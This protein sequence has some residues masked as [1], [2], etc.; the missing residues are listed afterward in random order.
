[1]SQQRKSLYHLNGPEKTA[2]AGSRFG[3]AALDTRHRDEEGL[4][5]ERNRQNDARVRGLSNAD[6]RPYRR[7]MPAPTLIAIFRLIETF[8]VSFIV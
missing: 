5:R 4:S 6:D 7:L 1:M 3:Q 8:Y 2:R